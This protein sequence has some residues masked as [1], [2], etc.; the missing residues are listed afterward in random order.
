MRGLELFKE[1]DLD[2]PASFLPFTVFDAVQEAFSRRR[3]LGIERPANDGLL[4]LP[5]RALNP[6]RPRRISNAFSSVPETVRFFV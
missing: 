4:R 2:V 3:M 1:L 5:L 6:S